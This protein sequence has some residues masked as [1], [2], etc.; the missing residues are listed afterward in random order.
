[1]AQMNV[2]NPSEKR[3]ALDI[4]LKMLRAAD[5]ELE[6]WMGNY[7]GGPSVMEN[8]INNFRHDCRRLLREINF[9]AKDQALNEYS[10]FV[11]KYKLWDTN[12][13]ESMTLTT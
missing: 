9:G 11:E 3:V 4:V 10:K 1:M 7:Y 6:S 2:L 8:E 5:L 13:I 12:Q